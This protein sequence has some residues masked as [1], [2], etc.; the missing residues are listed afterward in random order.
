MEVDS[1]HNQTWKNPYMELPQQIRKM[2]RAT[3]RVA[4]ALSDEKEPESSSKN[5]STKVGY[6]G[7][8]QIS[9]RA[10]PRRIPGLKEEFRIDMRMGMNHYKQAGVPPI[11][12]LPWRKGSHFWE[13][14]P[15]GMPAA[16]QLATEYKVNS[17]ASG[18]KF[19]DEAT[20]HSLT[21]Q[22]AFR[23]SNKEPPEEYTDVDIPSGVINVVEN[24]L[25]ICVSAAPE[26]FCCRL[27]VIQL[28]NQVEMTEEG[29]PF[30]HTLRE[31]TL[32]HFFSANPTE[33]K[34]SGSL[35]ITAF[36][37][38]NLS[39]K[40]PQLKGYKVLVDKTF[41]TDRNETHTSDI[42]F[43]FNFPLGVLGDECPMTL[44]DATTHS[45]YDQQ[46]AHKGNGRIIWGLFYELGDELNS[47]TT[48]SMQDIQNAIELIPHFYGDYKFKFHAVD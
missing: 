24:R 29:H 6:W 45:T 10:I 26:T 39:M 9:R 3:K 23:D 32:G 36:M 46:Y 37:D 33:A 31:Y 28:K 8:R 13:L 48:T 40:S 16:G 30:Y 17:T 41:T 21:H 38:K 43:D 1:K 20:Y 35:N 2:A 25:R 5:T 12:F 34:D 47:A 14:F 4:A 42:H 7:S 19:L 11:P 15:N 18:A 22:G 44:K 27:L